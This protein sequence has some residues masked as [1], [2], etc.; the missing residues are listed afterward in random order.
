VISPLPVSIDTVS[1]WAG[2]MADRTVQLVPVSAL[3]H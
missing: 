1:E 2:H 3:M